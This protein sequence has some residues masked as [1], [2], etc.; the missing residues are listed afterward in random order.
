MFH[1]MLR[2]DLDNQRFQ[3]LGPSLDNISY[4]WPTSAYPKIVYY[5][6]CLPKRIPIVEIIHYSIR[7]IVGR[8]LGK[9]PHF[10][11]MKILFKYSALLLFS[12]MITY[13]H[14]VSRQ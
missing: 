12:F 1:K 2:V 9:I 8:Y 14:K 5:Q 11:T 10:G 13:Q 3:A 4:L 6:F 7:V